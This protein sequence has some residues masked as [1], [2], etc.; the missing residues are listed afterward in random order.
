MKKEKGIARPHRQVMNELL[1]ADPDLAIEMLNE[2]L[3]DGPPE[4]IAVAVRRV[5]EAF[6]GVPHMARRVGV[7]VT[8]AYRSL[9][10]RGN[11][12]F[13]TVHAVLREAG[14][15]ISVHPRP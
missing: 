8:Q 1:R 11:P 10:R 5:V 12:S 2:T 15:D 9:S 4:E 7:N 6:G 14:L 3:R 13:R